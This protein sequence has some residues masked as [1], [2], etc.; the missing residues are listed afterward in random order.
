M[1][2][3][4]GTAFEATKADGGSASIE[5][6]MHFYSSPASRFFARISAPTGEINAEISEYVGQELSK[7]DRP[8]LATSKIVISGGRGLKSG[9]NF[10]ILYDVSDFL[11]ACRFQA[12]RF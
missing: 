4:R 10:K 8:D 6:C 2:T 12:V 1:L 7:S 11:R 9:D 5:D 3:V